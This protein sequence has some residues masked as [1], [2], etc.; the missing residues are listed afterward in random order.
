M[1]YG[2]EPLPAGE[3]RSMLQIAIENMLKR[4]FPAAFW[5]SMKMRRA[6]L[7]R[8]PQGEAA[9]RPI[10]QFDAMIAAIARSRGA[11][12]AT[13]NT[14]DFENC[15]AA[16]RGPVGGVTRV[17][18]GL[19][20]AHLHTHSHGKATGQVLLVS[21][22]VTL[23]FVAL[24]ALAGLRSGSL[25]LLSDAGHNFTD[26]FGLALAAAGYY[27][28]ARPSDHLRTFGYQRTG[29]LAAF[30]NALLLV[31]LSGALLWESYL[32]LLNPEPVSESVMLWVAAAGVVVNGAIAR[33][34]GHS[35]DLNLRAAWI[36]QI[37]DLASCIAIIAGA[38]VIHYTGWLQID[39][40]LSILISLVIVWTAWDIFK[41]SLNI[42]LEGLPKGLRLT[43]VISGIRS[44]AGVIDVHDL[45][46]WNVGAEERALSC[47]VLIEDVP[48]S[49]SESILRA[50]N[51]V[52][53]ERFGIHHTTIQFE[54]T[55][56]A[57]ADVSCAPG[58]KAHR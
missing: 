32:R 9:G 13:R 36:H 8:L 37:G 11:G 14:A 5:R 57:L 54:H 10:S 16:N 31:I 4:S 56:C 27:W 30:L 38:A 50:V 18:M 48:P 17:T 53:E 29:V 7:A 47:H 41:D 23:A 22:V 20:G 52:L 42:L 39:P 24:E 35:H 2:L 44:V 40:A 58:R 6:S 3:R 25:A 1:F 15:G 49:A 28:G 34:I 33:A 46:V 21:L 45:H 51:N 12:L 19:V 26:A 43:E 55:R